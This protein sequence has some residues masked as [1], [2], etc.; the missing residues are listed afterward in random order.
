MKQPCK[1]FFLALLVVL[2]P[3][4]VSGQWKPVSIT[5]INYQHDGSGSGYCVEGY[6]KSLEWEGY[7]GVITDIKVIGPSPCSYQSSLPWGMY[8]MYI[9]GYAVRTE[10]YGGHIAIPWSMGMTSDALEAFLATQT[11]SRR[12]H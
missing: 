12:Q 10:I 9:D 1:Y 7:K 4:C 5:V 2:L 6:L 11:H 8:Y 3:S